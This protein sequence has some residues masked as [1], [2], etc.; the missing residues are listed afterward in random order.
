MRL[1]TLNGAGLGISGRFSKRWGDY[2]RLLRLQHVVAEAT[3]DAV[4]VNMRLH[5]LATHAFSPMPPSPALPETPPKSAPSLS[6][7]MV[8]A[9]GQEKLTPAQQRFNDLLVQI[10]RL[11]GQIERLEAWSDKHRYA[12]IQALRESV[13]LSQAHRKSL[14]L[15]VHERLQTADFTDRQQRMARGLVRGLMAHLAA[16]NDPQVQALVDLYVSEADEQ[17]AVEEHAEAAQRLRERIEEAL[18]QPIE[19]PGQYQTPEEMMAAGMRQWQRQQQADEERKTAKRAARKA[20]KQ[21]QKKS[22][23]ADK[24]K[25][26]AA[27]TRELDAKSAIRTIFRQLASSLHPDR[28]PD[29]QE[30]LRKTGLMSEVNAAYEKNDLTTL[31]R[32]QMQVAQVNPQNKAG[33]ARMADDKLIAMSLLLKEQVAALEDDLD[34]LESR[35]SRELCVPVRADADEVEMTQSLQRIQAD[36]RHSA[37]SLAADLRRIQNDAELKRWLKEQW[38]LAKTTSA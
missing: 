17:E 24:G 6:A 5:H 27:Q 13:Q 20:Q 11:S 37:E 14:L 30:R 29:E 15:F 34:Q 18:G 7:L 28:E 25:V 9:S 35:L 1:R 2:Q 3:F 22:A 26:P 19:K 12:H 16:T 4:G 32:L 8:Q 31:L 23:A 10:E 38:Q 36:Q 33:T 21:A